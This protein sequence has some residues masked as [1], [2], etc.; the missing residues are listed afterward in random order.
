MSDFVR[1]V[2]WGNLV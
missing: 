2:I 1:R